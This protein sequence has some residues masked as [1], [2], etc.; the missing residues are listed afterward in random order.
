M[1]IYPQLTSSQTE[2]IFRL[3]EALKYRFK[4]SSLLISALTHS[5]AALSSTVT[6]T[7]AVA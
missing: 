6:E 7:E 4:H 3:Q 5:S 2:A 1:K